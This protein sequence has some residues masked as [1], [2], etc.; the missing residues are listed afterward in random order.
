MRILE[1]IYSDNFYA[2]GFMRILEL[3]HADNFLDIRT[4]PFLIRINP[5]LSVLNPNLSVV[6][7]FESEFIRGARMNATTD[8]RGF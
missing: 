5:L 7:R 2:H 4:Y 6:I 8:K 3:I 1:R